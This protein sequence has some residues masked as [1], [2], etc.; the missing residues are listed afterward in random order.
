MNK[1]FH[2]LG[3][4]FMVF[5]V[6]VLASCGG[7]STGGSN[8]SGGG[9]NLNVAFLPKAINNPYFDDFRIDKK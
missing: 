7:S 3:L 4:G 1:L 9:N 5:L 2:T 8:S 6:L